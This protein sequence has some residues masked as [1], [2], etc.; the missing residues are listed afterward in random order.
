[1]NPNAGAWAGLTVLAF[2]MAALLFVSAETLRYRRAWLSLAVFFGASVFHM[3]YLIKHHLVFLQRRLIG[4]CGGGKGARASDHHA[5]HFQ[6]VRRITCRAEVGSSFRSDAHSAVHLPRLLSL[7]ASVKPQRL[8][9]EQ[10][11]RPASQHLKHLFGATGRRFTLSSHM[12]EWKNS[13]AAR[14]S[15]S[16][17]IVANPEVP[18]GAKVQKDGSVYAHSAESSRELAVKA[19]LEL[20]EGKTA[21]LGCK[22]VT[23]LQ[24]NECWA[25]A[26]RAGYHSDWRAAAGADLGEAK[27]LA[28]AECERK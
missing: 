21:S 14:L 16:H 20:C 10:R 1:M 7:D 4:G 5:L 28:T 12:T 13:E 8:G 9:I 18:A 23:T 2:V 3:L 26:E 15:R 17:T 6:W 19:T 24:G 11:R 22:L 25:L 27:K